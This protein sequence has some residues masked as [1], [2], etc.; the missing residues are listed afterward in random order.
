M[1]ITPKRQAEEPV[2][3]N[4]GRR[5]DEDAK[6]RIL[7]AALE[8]LEEFGFAKTTVDGI[9]GRAG[10][11]KAT[12]YRWWPNKAAV[13]IEALRGAVSPEL[14]VPDTGELY[15][16]IRLQLRNFVKLLSGRRGRIFKAFAVAAQND[17]EVAEAFQ[18]LWRKPC[19]RTTKIG[20]ERHRRKALRESVDLDVVLDVMYGPLYYRLLIGGNGLAVDYTDAL[21]DIIVRGILRR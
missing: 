15:G 11:G 18:T 10:T 14:P 21:A 7:D 9:A 19:R 4:P 5:R 6:K 17:P 3:R 8:M 13:M 12:V 1:S 2:Y 20:L 16:D